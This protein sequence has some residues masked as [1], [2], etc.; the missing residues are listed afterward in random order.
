LGCLPGSSGRSFPP[1]DTSHFLPFCFEGRVY[2]FQALPFGRASTPLIVTTV[3]K[4]C[5]ASFHA[6]GLSPF[7]PR[8]LG[9]PLSMLHDP[10][11]AGLT[12]ATEG[13]PGRMGGERRQ[14]RAGFVP[15]LRR[16]PISH[17]GG[18]HVPYPGP[19][20]QIWVRQWRGVAVQVSQPGSLFSS[21]GCST[22]WLTKC[23][24]VT[25]TCIPFSSC[26]S[27]RAPPPRP[28][29]PI[30]LGPGGPLGADLEY[31]VLGARAPTP[32]LAC[33]AS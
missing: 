17:N 24:R 22:L 21:W 31:L 1:P 29:G 12:A 16:S 27:H 9:V 30:G 5:V 20:R 11:K 15:V 14:V 32:G 2:Q 8:R 25:L 28:I 7:L 13:P 19:D 18:S 33:P 10:R 3:S 6:F 26:L 4:A 23:L